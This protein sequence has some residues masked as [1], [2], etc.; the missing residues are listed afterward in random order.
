MRSLFAVCAAFALLACTEATQKIEQTIE[1]V[2][3]SNVGGRPA[4]HA[5]VGQAIPDFT[6]PLHG[7]GALSDESLKGKW[8]VVE[9]WG[10]WCGDCQ[11]DAEHTKALAS[12]ISQDPGLSFTTIHVSAKDP[13]T[14]FARWGSLE[15][16]IAEKGIAYPIAMDADRTAYKA[17][18]MEWVPTYLVV[19]PAGIVRG[20]RTD[21]NRDPS[22]EGGVKAF[23]KEIAALKSAG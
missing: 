14:N 4:R 21:L 22:P 2:E 12:A 15:A 19:D 5:L 3:K 18:Q 13:A 11:A 7:G 17:F 9:F 20:F 8:T 16:Y 6:L 23:L 1:Q 10:V